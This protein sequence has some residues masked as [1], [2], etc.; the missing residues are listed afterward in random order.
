MRRQ[1]TNLNARKV[2]EM[3]ETS[4]RTAYAVSKT[5]TR[6]ILVA[7]Y[8]PAFIAAAKCDLGAKW[9]SSAWTFDLRDEAEAM[10]LIQKFYGWN[11]GMALVSVKVYFDEEKRVGQGPF[12]LL[13][14]VLASATGRD[15]GA[16]L[17]DGVRLH[18][19][20]IGSGGS[21]KNWVTRIDEGTELVVHDVPQGMAS[22]YVAGT[23]SKEGVRIEFLELLAAPDTE[24]LASERR[25]LITRI[26]EIDKVLASAAGS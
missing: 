11:P 15:G 23:R 17:G 10:D 1:N 25:N 5:A 19:G 18:V 3:N 7:P 8:N 13:G 2:Y 22:S 20:G 14:R 26:A 9:N 24:T 21:M 12:V 4:I 16:R 6:L